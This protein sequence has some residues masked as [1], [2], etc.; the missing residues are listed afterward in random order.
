MDNTCWK[1]KGKLLLKKFIRFIFW[2]VYIVAFTQF[3]SY[4]ITVPMLSPNSPSTPCVPILA[5]TWHLQLILGP[6][7]SSSLFLVVLGTSG[8]NFSKLFNEFNAKY[9]HLHWRKISFT[10]SACFSRECFQFMLLCAWGAHSNRYE[11]FWCSKSI[12]HGG[13]L[14]L[15]SSI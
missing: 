12:F 4:R 1:S 2:Y 6:V 15:R 10:L 9:L 5:N 8:T 7:V 11:T 13:T 14:I 3:S